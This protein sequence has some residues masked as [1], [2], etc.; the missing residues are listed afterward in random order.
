[1][2]VP[3]HDLETAPESSRDALSHQAERVGKVINIF[4]AMANSPP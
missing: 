1:M 3:I 2:R 4:G